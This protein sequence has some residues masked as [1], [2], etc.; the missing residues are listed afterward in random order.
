[1]Y[2]P[3]YISL[4]QFD[5]RETINGR[6]AHHMKK[7]TSAA[8]EALFEEKHVWYAPVNTYEA[9][10][11]DPQV[12]HAGAI[13]SMEHPRAGTVQVLAHPVRYDG[14]TLPVRIPPPALGEHTKEILASLG[15]GDGE[16]EELIRRGVVKAR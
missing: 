9:V 8:W 11:A 3:S 14:E 5:Q 13:L 7:R 16:I 2:V 1:M 10:A 6:I 12:R 15:Y 4:Y